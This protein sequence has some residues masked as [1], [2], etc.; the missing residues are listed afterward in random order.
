MGFMARFA[1]RPPGAAGASIRVGQRAS[2]GPRPA[3]VGRLFR[4]RPCRFDGGAARTSGS[5]W[6]NLV[7]PPPLPA[8]PPPP[9]CGVTCPLHWASRAAAAGPPCRRPPGPGRPASESLPVPKSG[10]RPGRLDQ[11]ASRHL[12]RRQPRRLRARARAK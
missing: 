12:R 7:N 1:G 8:P 3:R 9:T 10:R 6:F 11:E 5:I 2:R 4:V